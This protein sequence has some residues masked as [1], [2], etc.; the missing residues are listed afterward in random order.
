MTVETLSEANLERAA[1]LFNKT[2]Q[3]NLRTRRLTAP[4]LLAWARG[5][6]VWTFR[7]ADTF[8]DYGLCGFASFVQSGSAGILFDFVLSCRVF[9]RGVEETMLAVVARHAGRVGC[10][11][12]VAELL[13]T[14]RNQ[15]CERWFAAQRGFARDGNAFRCPLDAARPV[16]GHV[17]V[18]GILADEEVPSTQAV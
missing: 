11:E 5:N 14:P 18:A 12:L 17:T 3:M 6:A 16:P 1:Q 7:I 2:N 8:G 9:G 4:D 10:T 15:P 13:P